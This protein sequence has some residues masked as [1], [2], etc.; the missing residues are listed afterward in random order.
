MPLA[1]VGEAHIQMNTRKNPNGPH[2]LDPASDCQPQCYSIA[3][4][5]A[6]G[7]VKLDQQESV[8]PD[9][10]KQSQWVDQSGII[11]SSNGIMDGMMIS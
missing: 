3:V 11:C 7:A 5:S 2:L 1:F 4:S 6:E 9:A 10:S 8:V